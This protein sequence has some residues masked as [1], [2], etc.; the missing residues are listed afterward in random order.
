M[1]NCAKN[2]RFL[3]LSLFAS[4]VSLYLGGCQSCSEKALARLIKYDGPTERDHDA[5][6]NQWHPA[7]K[8]DQFF[9]GD[10]I[11][12]GNG[13][14]T[15]LWLRDGS[16]LRMQ[17]NSL[18]RFAK[19]RPGK[20][21]I[22]LKIEEGVIFIDASS[23]DLTINTRY[24]VAVLE[25]G[26]RV[27]LTRGANGVILDVQIGKARF[28]GKDEQEQL[29]GEGERLKITMENAVLIPADEL[30]DDDTDAEKP[31]ATADQDTDESAEN[32]RIAAEDRKKRLLQIE[33]NGDNSTIVAEA[34]QPKPHLRV[35]AGGTTWIHSVAV[36]VNVAV[37][38]ADI[39]PHGGAV[40]LAGANSKYIGAMR[41]VVPLNLGKRRYQVFC[42]TESNQLK[43][44]AD[45][46]G[47][48]HV[49]RDKGKMKLALT[50]PMSTILMDGRTWNVNYQSRLPV[51]RVKWSTPPAGNDFTLH[52][53]GETKQKIPLSRPVHT[54]KSGK[55]KEG[56]H[57]IKFIEENSGVRSRSTTVRIQFDN[58]SDKA[59]LLAPREM[60]FG[61][62]ENVT[63]R[64]AA[65]PGWK[66]SGQGG[67]ISIDDAGR[68]EG[69][70]RHDG[71]YLA[72]W[73]RLSHPRRGVH[74][75]IRSAEK[76]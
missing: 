10:G 28:L 36:Q 4:L 6:Q 15:E 27:K 9:I 20:N 19:T 68:F 73:L 34:N 13:A 7:V 74:Y 18:I 50:P 2:R 64:G 65:M 60:G 31:G 55:L 38:F 29:L 72:V 66:V 32:G 63:V 16:G 59:V 30:D 61:I 23:E 26:T 75:Y 52:V 17:Q 71:N 12:T 70:L 41:A 62:G 57:K 76:K 54:F 44:R 47:M 35:A 14:T 40:K 3:F 5:T 69:T 11:R 46:S 51:I 48:L 33:S 56:T 45:A 22:G 37:D 49:V 58:V 21:Q 42:A 67:T 25:K 39:C 1:W 43:K 53:T 8:G 24:G